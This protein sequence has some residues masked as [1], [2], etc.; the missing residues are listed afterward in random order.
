MGI[1]RLL[2]ERAFPHA[3]IVDWDPLP[4]QLTG[5]GLKTKDRESFFEAL[6]ATKQEWFEIRD[7]EPT[8][9]RQKA[10]RY[11]TQDEA[12]RNYLEAQGLQVHRTEGPI[13][14]GGKVYL[15]RLVQGGQ[16]A[17]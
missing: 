11:L 8:F 3:T 13:R 6:S 10:W 5:R 2:L 1:P 15:Y 4:P 12:F 17:A 7:F 16:A 14:R 9:S